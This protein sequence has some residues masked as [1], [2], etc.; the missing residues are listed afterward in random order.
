M[1]TFD[2][3]TLPK[4]KKELKSVEEARSLLQTRKSLADQVQTDVIVIDKLAQE[5]RDIERRIES[6]LKANPSQE[7]SVGGDL[8]TLTDEKKRLDEEFNELGKRIAGARER[9]DAYYERAKR[10]NGLREKLNEMKTRRGELEMRSQKK[11]SLSEKRDELRREMEEAESECGKLGDKLKVA[12]KA[13]SELQK[14]RESMLDE[15]KGASDSRRKMSDELNKLSERMSELSRAIETF[16]ANDL[17]RLEKLRKEIKSFDTDERQVS[18]LEPFLN[19]PFI[20]IYKVVY[21]RFYM[22]PKQIA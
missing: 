9:I 19:K 3:D 22:R 4:L 6:Y 12:A 15:Q 17:P 14:Q 16:E 21:Y 18:Y 10:V 13:L 20:Y 11:T 7:I 2:K 5:S 8:S 1:D